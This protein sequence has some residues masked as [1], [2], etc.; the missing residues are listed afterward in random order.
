MYGVMFTVPCIQLLM[1][2]TKADLTAFICERL[3]FT[4]CMVMYS[5]GSFILERER[6]RKQ[7]YFFFDL[8]NSLM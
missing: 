7:K 4:F 3:N 5:K 2:K 1:Q 6:K 8:C